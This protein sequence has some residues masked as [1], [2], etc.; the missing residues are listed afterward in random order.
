MHG[1]KDS[2]HSKARKAD[3]MGCTCV[4]CFFVPVRNVSHDVGA[5]HLNFSC[6]RLK[7]RHLYVCFFRLFRTRFFDLQPTNSTVAERTPS[8]ARCGAAEF[9]STTGTPAVGRT[10]YTPGSTIRLRRAVPRCC[11]R[12]GCGTFEFFMLKVASLVRMFF[13]IVPHPFFDLRNFE[14]YPRIIGKLH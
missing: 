2:C 13:S 12:H 10:G 14:I 5:G 11:I 1:R 6:F 7:L 4:P 9:R 8:A 3:S